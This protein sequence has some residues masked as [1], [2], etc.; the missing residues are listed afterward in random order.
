MTLRFRDDLESLVGN[1][2]SFWTS[3]GGN[4]PFVDAS[5]SVC[6]GHLFKWQSLQSLRENL[7]TVVIMMPFFFVCLFTG[8]PNE[9][10]QT[11]AE[12]SAA[13]LHA[14]PRVPGHCI[15]CFPSSDQLLCNLCSLYSMSSHG[16]GQ[17]YF[18]KQEEGCTLVM[19]VTLPAHSQ[20]AVTL[21]L[22]LNLCSQSTSR[23][24]ILLSAHLTYGKVEVH[25]D[26][27]PLH[28]DTVVRNAHL[29]ACVWWGMYAC[30]FAGIHEEARGILL[31]HFLHD[32]LRIRSL[33]EP[34][35]RLAASRLQ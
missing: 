7:L 25:R 34:G 15:L 20:Q 9:N 10:G 17:G 23:T 11:K 28:N 13:K 33:T 26:K 19:K 29:C 35:A 22:G 18:F 2:F 4:I 31:S 14:G 32:F 8:L 5:D 30:I 21:S 3:G 12:M 24:K 1:E 16:H 6:Y 27:W